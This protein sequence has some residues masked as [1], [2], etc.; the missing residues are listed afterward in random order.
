[1]CNRCREAGA[2]LAAFLLGA[3][4]GAAAGLLLAPAKGETTRK[5]LKRWANDTYEDNKE[6]MLEHA[7]DMKEKAKEHFEAAREKFNEGKEKAVKEFNRRKDE[8]VAK[9]KKDEDK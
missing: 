5:K 1:M 6:L 2:G 8:V 3:V 7:H 4:V 9:F